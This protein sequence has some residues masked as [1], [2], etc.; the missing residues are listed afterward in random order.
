MARSPI[1]AIY[2]SRA[3]VLLK[4]TYHHTGRACLYDYELLGQKG[5]TNLNI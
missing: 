3:G 5:S 4:V 1:G 2:T